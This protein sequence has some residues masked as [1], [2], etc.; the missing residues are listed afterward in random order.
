MTHQ[1]PSP[2][3]KHPIPGVARTGFL[4]PFITRPNIIVG[5]YT[6][7]DDPLGPEHFEDNVL[8][9]F[10]FIG[11]FATHYGIFPGCGTSIPFATSDAQKPSGGSGCC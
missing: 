5:D 4:K 10:D 6:Y 3:E 1:G 7:Y 2:D 9:H 8:Y 11:D